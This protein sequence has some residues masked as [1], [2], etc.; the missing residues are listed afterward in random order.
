MPGKN[1]IKDYIPDH[2]YHV[3]NRGW[4]RGAIFL[5][6]EDYEQFEY[7][8]GRALSRTPSKDSKGR[9]YKWLRDD[10]DL[11]AYCLMPNHFH[12]LVYQRTEQG[13]TKLVQ[14]VCTAYTMYFNKRY[15][16]RGSLFENRFKAVPIFRDNQ[17]Q[18]ISRYIHL[19]HK[20][21]RAWPHSS[22]GDYLNPAAAREWLA[23]QP[24][25]D[26]FDSI[27]QYRSFVLDYEQAQREHDILKRELAD[28]I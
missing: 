11:N 13:I 4:N 23:P 28:A 2:Y 5:D 16:R 24:I 20:N 12:M 26:I 17:L 27:E 7:L 18:H 8:L 25:L 9:E 3:Y 1:T 15:K 22:Y 19:N 10:L 21:F 6:Q 14:S